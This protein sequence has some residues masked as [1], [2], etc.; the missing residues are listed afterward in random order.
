M[1]R[2]PVDSSI[3]RLLNVPP[4]TP[5]QADLALQHAKSQLIWMPQTLKTGEIDDEGYKNLL[6]QL[7]TDRPQEKDI[8]LCKG[9]PTEIIRAILDKKAKIELQRQQA[10]Q[11]AAATGVLMD[12]HVQDEATTYE[13]AGLLKKKGVKPDFVAGTE[14]EPE[15]KRKYY[16][17]LLSDIAVLVNFFGR[18]GVDW[19]VERINTVQRM[20]TTNNY[21]LHCC[22][23]YLAPP[24]KS[25]EELNAILRFIQQHT[26]KLRQMTLELVDDP[27]KLLSL[28]Q[29]S[30]GAS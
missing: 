27:D 18:V 2:L 24:Q 17:S 10:G 8:E 13:L 30:R 4:A 25:A 5:K 21:G 9:L 7:Q 19:V 14:H 6:N 26:L 29:K 3:L 22:S 28:V 20:V 11:T 16:E 12:Y 15:E 23:I 1:Q